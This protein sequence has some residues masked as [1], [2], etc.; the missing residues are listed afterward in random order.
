MSLTVP[1]IQSAVRNRFS[2]HKYELFNSY[3]FNGWECDFFSVTDSGYCYEVEVKLSRGDFFADF[4][5][6]KHEL[7]RKIIAGKTF[8]FKNCG[9]DRYNGSVIGKYTTAELYHKRHGYKQKNKTVEEMATHQDYLNGYKHFDLFFQ[10]KKIHAP[11]TRIEHVDLV[12]VNCPNRFYYACPEGLI[13]K[14]EI[15]H[16]AGLIYVRKPHDA[17]TEKEAPF[18]HKRKQDLNKI[19]LDKFYW[20]SKK[21]RD[22]IY[23]HGLN[24]SNDEN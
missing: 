10:T 8:Y 5:K 18:L 15:P 9:A 14:T 16:Y 22:K 4:K 17:Y 6:E 3:V 19:L 20:E 11:A 21:L 2:N 7:F 24:N 1:N 12:K 23:Y 13:K